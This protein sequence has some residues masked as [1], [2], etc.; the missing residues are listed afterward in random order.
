MKK[1]IILVGIISV[2]ILYSCSFNGNTF[3]CDEC[4]SK[5]TL[6]EFDIEED[7]ETTRT[8]PSYTCRDCEYEKGY[9]DGYNALLDKI[10]DGDIPSDYIDEMPDE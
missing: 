9:I 8:L 4:G 10:Y 2:T 6:E 5:F 7:E 1:F 3:Y